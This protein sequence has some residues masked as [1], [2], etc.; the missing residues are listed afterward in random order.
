MPSHLGQE[1]KHAEEVHV[2]LL[3]D[4]TIDNR[5]WVDGLVKNY[6]FT[7][8]GIK[9]DEPVERVRK[10]HRLLWK[11]ALSVVEN[12]M[13]ILPSSYVLHDYTNDGF[14][15]GD[16]LRGAT[17][18]KVFGQGLGTFSLFPQEWFQPLKEGANSIRQSRHIIVSIGGNDF[19]EFL[20]VAN[21]KKGEVRAHYIKQNLESVLEKMRNQ[22]VEIIQRIREQNQDAQIILM[23][24]YYPSATQNNYKIYPFMREIGVILG[25]R[26][27]AMK[28]IH[29]I[30][31]RTY[32]YILKNVQQDNIVV[33]DITSSLNLY[34]AQNY[35]RQIEPSG[36]GG[37]KIAQM[38]KYIMTS[39]KVV[40]GQAYR[41]YPEFFTAA[42]QDAHVEGSDLRQW[43][44]AHPYDL[45]EGYTLEEEKIF[46]EYSAE[47]I[48]VDLL[49]GMLYQAIQR[50]DESSPIY[51]AAW[52]LY[53]EGYK[54]SRLMPENNIKKLKMS[55][56]LAINLL[57]TPNDSLD[58]PEAIR[59]L[60][61]N[62]EHRAIGTADRG[63]QFKGALLALAGAAII[64]LSLA[65]IPFTGGASTVLAFGGISAIG[66]AS[67][68]YHHRQK[69]LSK[70]S[71]VL[72]KEAG[73]QQRL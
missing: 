52:A 54:L 5:I 60:K 14:T 19:R 51:S 32:D 67:F 27:N 4:S 10:S 63:K 23:T 16:V 15:T 48:T 49:L 73:R 55:V 62:A 46:R 11:P 1:E 41:F 69:S 30:M 36:V 37:K 31:K 13:D 59:L 38:L 57:D 8:L 18:D 39:P 21:S 45:R 25:I 29:E 43:T 50:V 56:V 2:T 22:Y 58:Y 17:K 47:G 61:E 72:A 71:A 7:R 12:M 44:P 64:A 35:V 42:E 24:Q 40:L 9:R 3:G 6:I 28:V 66:G 33:A 34:D 68:F 70:E 20:Q 53:K 26:G 65:G